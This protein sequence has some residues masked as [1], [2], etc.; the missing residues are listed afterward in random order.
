[1]K[2]SPLRHKLTHEITEFLAVFLFLAPFFLA[3]TNY[4]MY[5]QGNFSHLYLAYGMSLFNALVL[6]KIILIGEL[7]HLGGR[8]RNRP[9]LFITVDKAAVF[10]VLYFIF[11]LLEDGVRGSLRGKGFLE[12]IRAEDFANIGGF[13]ARLLFV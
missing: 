13:F 4:R 1:M 6:S 11:H 2:D 7:I 9:L 5:L 12:A 3:I 10:T 8:S